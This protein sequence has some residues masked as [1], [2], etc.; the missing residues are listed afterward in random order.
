MCLIKT[1]EAGQAYV[2]LSR[3]KSLDSLRVL[4]FNPK[5]VWADPEVLRFYRNLNSFVQE[6]IPIGK[7][8]VKSKYSS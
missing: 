7:K 8:S 4:G 1:F 6:Y 2:A 3:A 5:Q